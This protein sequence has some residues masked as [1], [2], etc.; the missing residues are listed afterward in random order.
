MAT[1]SDKQAMLSSEL[2]Q[3]LL[4]LKDKLATAWAGKEAR[5][6]QGDFVEL[7]QRIMADADSEALHSETGYAEY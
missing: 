3:Q 6:Q 1:R 5:P 2:F 7:L 4:Q